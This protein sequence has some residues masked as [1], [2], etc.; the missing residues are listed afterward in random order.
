[1][2]WAAELAIVIPVTVTLY[3][4]DN[5][6]QFYLKKWNIFQLTF[7]F[8]WFEFPEILWRSVRGAVV[9]QFV[10]WQSP[11]AV[12]VDVLSIKAVIRVL[13]AEWV[14]LSGS[15]IYDVATPAFSFHKDTAQDNQSPLIGTCL[16]WSCVFMALEYV[17]SM[18]G[19]NILQGAVMT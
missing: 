19:K 15:E 8:D 11:V 1:M 4:S 13:G 14:L 17:A 12:D 6:L 9:R 16:A 2:E 7:N 3:G 18:H 10:P 5:K